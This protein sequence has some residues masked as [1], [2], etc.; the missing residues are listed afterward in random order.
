LKAIIL[1][2]GG[3]D[4]TVMLAQALHNGRKCMALSFDY[5]QRNRVE[6]NSAKKI[7]AY[8][9]ISHRVITLNNSTFNQSGLI[10][11]NTL[12]PSN[13]TF[14]QI[15]SSGIPI[16]YVPARNTLFI[17]Y[18]MGLAEITSADEIYMGANATDLNSYPDCRPVFFS[19]FQSLIDVATKQATEGTA[20]RIVTPLIHLDKKA[21]ISE[22]LRLGAPLDE[23]FSCYAPLESGLACG[24]CDACM[25]RNA[26]FKAAREHFENK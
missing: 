9:Q 18:A 17:A 12:L 13:R 15:A 23:T 16:T 5:G 4:S 8:Y 22:G 20:P 25:L 2:S 6:L 21:I 10:D 1:F 26:G 3:V 14:D 11:E 7:A 19:A 24:N